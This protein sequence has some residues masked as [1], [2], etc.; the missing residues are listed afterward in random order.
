MP[1]LAFA[2]YMKV[3]LQVSGQLLSTV[4]RKAYFLLNYWFIDARQPHAVMHEAFTDNRT[5]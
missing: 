4:G 2:V 1:R 3:S 5:M